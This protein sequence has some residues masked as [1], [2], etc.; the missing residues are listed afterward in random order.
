MKKILLPVCTLLFFLNGTSAFSQ[1]LNFEDET[2]D[3]I[4]I[5]TITDNENPDVVDDMEK[6]F[7]VA[8]FDND[9]FQ[10]LVVV[11]K[12]PFSFEGAKTDLLLMNNGNGV[13]EDQT[14]VLAPEFLTDPTDARDAITVDIDLDGWMD[15]FI[16]NTFQDQPKL[17]MN[18]GNDTDGNWLGLED[19]TDTRLPSL[20]IDVIQFCAAIAGDLTGDEYPEIY[21]V[22]YSQ[23]GPVLDV[24]YIND[25]NGN[26][27]EEAQSRMGNLRTSSFG[28]ATEFHDVDN[29]GDLDIIKCLGAGG[30]PVVPFND[31]GLFTM[32]NNGDGTF[33]NFQR[34]PGPAPYMFTASDLDDDG[35]LDFYTVDDFQDYV[36][37]TGAIQIDQNV[38]YTQQM[39][40]SDRTDVWGGN[41][42]M[43]DLDGDGDQDVT[44]ASVDT[45][46]PPCDTSEDNGQNGGIRTFTLF[47]NEGVFGGAI[48]DPYENQDNIWN[49]GN[50]DQDFIDINNDGLLDIILGACEGYMFLIQEETLAVD[51]V[52][53]SISETISIFPNPSNGIMNIRMNDVQSEEIL[54][55]VYTV[56]GRLLTSISR[57]ATLSNTQVFDVD[58]TEQASSGIYFMKFTTDQGTTTKK[59]IIE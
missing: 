38:I 32:F 28:T 54:I 16:V 51:D 59:I 12:T 20:T 56:T 39:L 9:S 6:D 22:N 27:T 17:Y 33:T 26:F 49:I 8:D 46:E 45:D 5:S 15:I 43:V 37:Y 10:D 40:T 13:L 7:L 36:N 25:G 24:L 50:Y 23:T 44:I 48:I 11:R 3:R 42:K 14:D 52:S 19:Q 31:Q 4:V 41:V 18:R 30:G 57:D 47:E 29:D 1:W 35:D 21:M 58:I 2:E 55:D 53:T 34:F